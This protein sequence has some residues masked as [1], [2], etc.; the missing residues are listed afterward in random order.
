MFDT[1]L[2]FAF[3]I[4]NSIV[5]FGLGK[6]IEEYNEMERKLEND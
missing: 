1:Y 2:M 5:F 3:F 4:F 6:I